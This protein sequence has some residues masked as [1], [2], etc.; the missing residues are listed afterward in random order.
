[1]KRSAVTSSI[2]SSFSFRP[3][4]PL[5]SR[6]LQTVGQPPGGG[7]GSSSS[8]FQG[9]CM[10]YKS[11]PS[12]PCRHAK[13]IHKSQD[14]SELRFQCVMT[15]QQSTLG[16]SSWTRLPMSDL[17]SCGL[18]WQSG[19]SPFSPVQWAGCCRYR[20]TPSLEC[21]RWAGSIRLCKAISRLKLCVGV[22]HKSQACSICPDLTA[23]N[24]PRDCPTSTID[25]N[26]LRFKL[27][28]AVCTNRG[29]YFHH[30]LYRSSCGPGAQVQ[31][32][33]MAGREPSP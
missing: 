1:M 26:E 21:N 7:G 4:H 27:A 25:A 18:P 19:H 17:R 31:R 10:T 23:I 32:D 28:L 6:R 16:A 22:A 24:L 9:V 8:S 12:I 15:F 20:K 11:W 2:L 13:D 3:H 33:G 30:S 14:A 29:S 5:H